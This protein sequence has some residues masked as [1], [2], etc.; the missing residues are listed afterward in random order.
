MESFIEHPH[1]KWTTLKIFP[2]LAEL[3][4]ETGLLNDIIA[5]YGN[6]VNVVINSP[7]QDFIHERLTPHQDGKINIV[8][9]EYPY[10]QRYNIVSQGDIVIAPGT[11]GVSLRS[12]KRFYTK[13]GV[14]Y[15][16]PPD[17]DNLVCLAM[18]VK[19][20]GPGFGNVL[21]ANLPFFDYWVILD[22]GSTDGTQEII[23]QTLHQKRGKLY[24]EPFVNFKVSRNRCLDL[25]GTVCQ[26][27]LMLDDTYILKGDVRKFLTETRGDTFADSYSLMIQSND[28]EYY[29]NRIIKSRTS[30]R[31]IHT[32][33]EVITDK[34]NNN[35]TIP[36]D[37][38][39][40]FDTRSE[41]MEQRTL[42]RKQFDLEL[43][44]KELETTPDDPRTL[45][46]IAQTYGCIGDEIHKAVY[47]EKR[48]KLDGY[49]QEKIDSLFELARTYNFKLNSETMQLMEPDTKLTPIQWKK[50]EEL[51]QEAYRLDPKRPDSLYFIGIHYYLAKDYTTAHE[52]FNLAFEVGYP[53]NS[54]YSLKPTLSYHFLPKF[55][56]ET[57]YYNENYQLGLKAAELFLN[58]N[59]PTD[60]S[61]NLVS[62]WYKIHL[63]LVK[64][65]PTPKIFCLVTD[66]GWEPWTGSTIET[67]GLG[68]SETWIIET[69]R[70][71]KDSFNVVVFCNTDKSEMYDGVGYNPITRFHEFIA[72]TPVEYCVV[73][74]FTE[75]VPVALKGLAKN[76]GVIFHDLILPETIIPL[77]PKIKCL[78]GLTEWHQHRIKELFPSFNV[79]YLNYGINFPE[80]TPPPVKVR[81]S[82]IYSS[83][84]NRGLVVLLEMWSEIKRLIPDA[85]LN[86]YCDL[87]QEW[88]NQVAPETMKKV[89]EMINQNGVTNHGWVSKQVLMKAWSSTDYWLYPCTFEETF[90]L[91]ALEAAVTRTFVITNGLAALSET[92]K[93]GITVEGN[94]LTAEWK[95]RCLAK[96]KGIIKN[97][98][99]KNTILNRNENWAKTMSW[100]SQTERFKNKIKQNN[101]QN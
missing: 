19:D 88:V 31:Y 74:R 95:L 17:Y 94:P 42:N 93:H 84:P 23:K 68:G 64:M 71:L 11:T 85:T 25:A 9:S 98:N 82:F 37:E 87:Q 83:F 67:K 5:F 38:A 89:K 61:W 59:K 35:V 99:L 34:D 46:Y 48:I 8:Y 79:D 66:G 47:F 24:E 77:D 40:I 96:L 29:S 54:Q 3:E 81:N 57:S 10:K 70:N 28:S 101:V 56:T 92:A 80:N 86:V 4:F 30:L 62:N 50:C 51:Y 43:L 53:L 18:I 69:A 26:F 1:P 15:S 75:Y 12:G 58:K 60:H 55:L 63:N 33:H 52:Y 36:P 41:Y 16:L 91:T 27:I 73:S 13:P 20:A 22:T 72:S 7:H 65:P 2:K 14:K 44:F 39:Y 97:E 32:I 90:C 45:Y 100:K 6:Q 49:I 76:V 78:L 21:T